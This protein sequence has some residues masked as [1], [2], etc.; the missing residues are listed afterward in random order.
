[1]KTCLHAIKCS[2]TVPLG[3]MLRILNASHSMIAFLWPVAWRLID[4]SYLSMR[5]FNPG[6]AITP[7]LHKKSFTNLKSTL[8]NLSS[9]DLN[10]I[11]E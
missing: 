5:G 10:F 11:I 3:V 7:S 2:L 9:D 8:S 1:M 6:C 4:P